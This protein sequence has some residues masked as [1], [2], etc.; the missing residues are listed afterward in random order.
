MS[1]HNAIATSQNLKELENCTSLHELPKLLTKIHFELCS[2]VPLADLEA[3][4]FSKT[5]PKT[6]EY[7]EALREQLLNL[8]D[9]A[10]MIED[11]ISL[12]TSLDA[13]AKYILQI[14]QDNANVEPRLIE[15]F[16]VTALFVIKSCN[17]F[18]SDLG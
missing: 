7:F 12:L 1:Q 2:T 17:K 14:T 18:C 3:Q 16:P 11:A 9:V 8:Q 6:R 5:C 10:S 13:V 4:I 15:S